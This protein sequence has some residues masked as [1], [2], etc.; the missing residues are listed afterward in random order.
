MTSTN[1]NLSYT[2]TVLGRHYGT[3]RMKIIENKGR[4]TVSRIV[5]TVVE[6]IEEEI[7]LTAR[8]KLL[9]LYA[10]D[11]STS[12][13][14]FWDGTRYLNEKAAFVL[15]AE[16]PLYPLFLY[17]L[18]NIKALKKKIITDYV[19][20]V[21]IKSSQVKIKKIQYI[22]EDQSNVTVIVPDNT[23]LNYSNDD[24]FLNS[25]YCQNSGIKKERII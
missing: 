13:T 18:N 16:Y 3:E 15:S 19:W 2:I 21:D 4:T 9:R 10:N 11:G 20:A 24:G 12:V 14:I 6:K 25:M 8:G 23:K 22:R 5:D 7:V 17:S 1:I